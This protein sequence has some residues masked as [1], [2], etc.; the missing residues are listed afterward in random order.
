LRS[1]EA[2]EAKHSPLTNIPQC[3][4]KNYFKIAWRN[5]SKY[6]F[7]SAVNILGLFAGIVFALLIGAYIWSELQVNKNLRNANRQYILTTRS[8]DPNVG[9]ELATFGP[10]AKSLKEEYPSLVENYYRYDGVTSVVSKGDKH[11]REGL[12]IGDSTMLK[13]FG[14][15]VLHGDVQT[16]LDNPYSV[17]I[18]EEKAIK[19]FGKTDVVGESISVQSFSGGNHDFNITAVLKNLPT[20][21]ISNLAKDYPNN[22]FVP[23]S[24]SNYFGRQGVDSW[25]NIFIASYVE[26]REGVSAKDLEAPIR[27]LVQ[28]NA[29]DQLKK[30]ITVKPIL[31]SDYYLQQDQG[32]VKRMLYT[33]SFVGLFILLMAIIN[34]I[35]I[36]ISRS[37][38][39]MKEIGI[40]KVLGSMKRQLVFQFLTESIILVSI[41]TV[42]ALLTYPYLRPLFGQLVGKDL[43]SLAE[44]PSYF[45]CLPVVLVIVVGI[46]AGLYPAFVLSAM[47][48]VDSLKGKLKTAKDK[49]I[50]RKSLVGFQF[51]IALIVLI[52]AGV[53]SH[54]VS[55]FFSQHLG[56]DKEFVVSAQV[57]RDWSSAG[58]KKM[59]T[60]RDEFSKLPEVS[61]V[62]LS[63]EI[64]DGANGGQAPVYKFGSDSTQAISMQILSPDEHF[65]SVYG[66]KL[67]FGKFINSTGSV[68]SSRIVLN[69]QAV[70]VLGW[71]NDND[72]LN[73]QVR[74]PG[75]NTVYTIDGIT[76]DFHFG[77]MQ[78]Q[79]PPIIFV[80]VTRTHSY[81]YLSFKL[82]PGNISQSIEVIQK[83]WATLLP[84]TSFEY[85]FMEDTLRKLYANELQLK[86]A[87]YLATVLALL[88]VLLGV[89]GLVSLSIHKRIKEVGIRKVLGASVPNIIGL[90]AREFAVIVII[91]G[92]AACPFA[93]YLMNGWLNNYAYR[94]TIG[95]QPF[96]IA[97]SLLAGVTL[98]LVAVQVTR[99]LK[100][101]VVQNLKTE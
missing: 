19:Y 22:F 87:A 92:A 26:T 83:K 48:S 99:A 86:K 81:R 75:D 35:N 9:Y 17:V 69:E 90:F 4:L 67:K 40:R 97:I 14:F 11:F 85:K 37:A 34:F 21:S 7:Y 52:A 1:A 62:S 2:G 91:A 43:P 24:A 6:R 88:I 42:L 15:E 10:I 72:A 57:P 23:M 71:K 100:Q 51:S 39:R 63:Y 96:I 36:A 53:V 59:L 58:V 41:A 101:N 44:F 38:S 3:M 29:S 50:L 98:L 25:N 12:Q 84:G 16:A 5:L 20:N 33:L 74:V 46:S 73:Q 60:I 64:P 30:I 13:M 54:Q 18:T 56:Y 89:L 47:K 77:S 68:D 66:I 79:V 82:K 8:T 49:I 70:K 95:S 31:L 65:L 28:Q 32:L 93:W 61:D 80:N 94:I 78:T 27:Q 45:V 76:D 55:Y